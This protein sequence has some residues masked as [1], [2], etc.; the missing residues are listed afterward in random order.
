MH[1]S[2]E[3]LQ[4]LGMPWCVKNIRTG[5]DRCSGNRAGTSHDTR[6]FQSSRFIGTAV[7]HNLVLQWSQKRVRCGVLPSDRLMALSFASVFTWIGQHNFWRTTH[8]VIT[9]TDKIPA[10][11]LFIRICIVY[12]QEV[13]WDSDRVLDP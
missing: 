1:P 13:C 10:M 11:S 7:D 9:T 12:P 8:I 2:R 3:Y 4:R 6:R 5:D